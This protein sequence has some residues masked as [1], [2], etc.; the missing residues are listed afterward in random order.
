MRFAAAKKTSM[1][2]SHIRTWCRILL[3]C[4]TAVALFFAIDVVVLKNKMKEVAKR[5]RSSGKAA[6]A[7]SLKQ[8]LEVLTCQ[9]SPTA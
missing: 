7:Q 2:E 4:P 3:Q 8:V 5:L 6:Y 9:L 1:F